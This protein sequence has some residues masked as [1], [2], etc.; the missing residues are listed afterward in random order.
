M[1]GVFMKSKPREDGQMV[2]LL[3]AC[4]EAYSLKVARDNRWK[5]AC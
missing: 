3:Y 2:I 5:S 1:E 4:N